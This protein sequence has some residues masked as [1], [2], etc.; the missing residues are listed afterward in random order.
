M[1]K[2]ENNMEREEIEHETKG[3]EIQSCRT[4]GRRKEKKEH[5]IDGGGKERKIDR[6]IDR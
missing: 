3:K 2:D 6:L 5:V 1:K 4:I